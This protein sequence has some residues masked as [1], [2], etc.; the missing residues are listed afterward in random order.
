M[1]GRQTVTCVKC[2]GSIDKDEYGWVYNEKSRRY[3]CFWCVNKAKRTTFRRTSSQKA[4][5]VGKQYHAPSEKTYEV[6][7]TLSKIAGIF[8]LVL[9][10]LLMLA[11]PPVGIFFAVLGIAFFFFGKSYVKKANAMNTEVNETEE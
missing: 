1:A 10:L 7:G 3:T 4:Y 2:G 11:V 9:S 8:I 6:V 5:K